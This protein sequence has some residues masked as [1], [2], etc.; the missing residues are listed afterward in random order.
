MIKRKK[1]FI[2]L[3]RKKRGLHYTLGWL[4]SAYTYGSIELEEM[5]I[6]ELEMLKLVAL[7]D[8]DNG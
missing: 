4:E 5:K 7:P 8:Y 3:L 2:D 1:E 6:V